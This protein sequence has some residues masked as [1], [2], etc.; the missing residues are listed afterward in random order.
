MNSQKSD[1]TF[2]YNLKQGRHGW[3][4]LTPAY[5][6]KVVENLLARIDNPQRVLDPFSGTGTTGLV[7]A[8][9]GISCDL[10][11]IN[12]FLAWLAEAKIYNY[13][14]VE[15]EASYKLVKSV[16]KEARQNPQERNLWIPP[17]KNIERW[18]EPERL[19]TLANLFMGL[20]LYR[21]ERGD[22]PEFKLAAIA[23]CRVAIN[24]SNAAF[25]H[26]SMSLK[27]TQPLLFRSAET[28]LII[29]DFL[30]QYRE[31]VASARLPIISKVNLHQGNS[32][33]LNSL[34]SNSYD[35]V[36]TSPPYPNRISYIREVRPYMY[37][38]GFL[39]EARE[40]GELDWQAIGGTWG[41]ATSRLQNWQP[42]EEEISYPGWK[43]LVGQIR[44][45]SP[46]L[47]NYVRKYFSDIATH[48]SHLTQVLA[49]GAKI[50]YVVGNSKFYETLI[51]VEKIYASLLMEAGFSNLKTE[52][53]RKRNSKKELYE[54]VVS[55]EWK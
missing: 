25:N 39:K 29:D 8:Q 10:V 21:K 26:Q 23:F 15:L 19:I 30:F 13:N 35:L 7:C 45:R 3:L 51:P 43:C 18:W 48:L 53:L 46:I 20:N 52:V 49:A 11:E 5:S 4:R 2:K 38:L 9:R 54:Y 6:I 27:K 50:F 44:D 33:Y 14:L 36:I 22:T 47:A 28:D 34:L 24:W 12:P 31:I 41:I 1:L 42:D 32:R 17:L 55:A 40:A 37:W 16:A